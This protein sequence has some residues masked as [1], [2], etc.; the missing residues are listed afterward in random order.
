MTL[1]GVTDNH[2]TIQSAHKARLLATLKACNMRRVTQISLAQHLMVCEIDVIKERRR[3]EVTD[4]RRSP[5]Q[6]MASEFDSQK[7]RVQ[8]D[9]V[10]PETGGHAI[11]GLRQDRLGFTLH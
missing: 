5:R 7:A 4:R 1:D 6:S 3:R 9:F 8:L 11:D 10:L 2:A